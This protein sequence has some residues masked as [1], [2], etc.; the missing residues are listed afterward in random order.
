VS[1][2]LT[3]GPLGGV[4]VATATFVNGELTFAAVHVYVVEAPGAIVPIVWS[5]FG[6]STSVTTT[7][8]SVTE[9]V[10]VTVIE[11]VAMPPLATVCVSGLFWIEIPGVP[12][13]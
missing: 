4:P 8:V 5:Q 1:L 11:K 10:L 13:G 6:V 3:F 9:P 2:A 12:G 7:F